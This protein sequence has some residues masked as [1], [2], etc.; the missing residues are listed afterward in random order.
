M[1]KLIQ[2]YIFIKNFNY[3]I[4]L[5]YRVML[6][7]Y[8][9]RNFLIKLPPFFFFFKNKNMLKFLFINYMYYKNFYK[10]IF[11]FYSK[12][13]PFYYFKL[14]LKGLGFRVR[15]L[16][17]FL[18]RIYYNRSNY[19]YMHISNSILLK[20]RTRQLFFLS[21]NNITLKLSIINLLLLKKFSVYR[22]NGLI[23]PRIIL[24][25]KPGKNKFR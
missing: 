17:K 5:E 21:T 6:I 1:Q 9:S 7:L 13:F 24:L 19:Y 15:I 14:K 4:N 22:F 10:Y 3:F 11:R 20:Y 8:K 16:S 18:I 2:K 25:V 23:Y 12:F